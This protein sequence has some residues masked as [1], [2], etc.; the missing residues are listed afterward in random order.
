MTQEATHCPDCETE[1]QLIK[2]IDNGAPCFGQTEIAYATPDAKR[3]NWT[4]RFPE[5]GR[6]VAKICPSCGRVLLFGS[7][8]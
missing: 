5:K 1:M 2:L 7:R 6:L 4:G 8:K 3:D